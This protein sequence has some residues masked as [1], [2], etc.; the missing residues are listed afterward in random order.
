MDVLEA[1]SSRYS[2]PPFCR[3]QS[4]NKLSATSSSAPR[5]P[6]AGNM[7]P[8]RVYAIAGKRVEDLKAALA[9]RMVTELPK[10]EGTD[11]AIYPEP[12][13]T[14][15]MGLFSPHCAGVPEAS[16]PFNDLFGHGPRL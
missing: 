12:L 6:S 9:P 1:V 16:R 15:G 8:W 10:G 14:T 5:A 4:P 13:S 11:Y 3:P 7:Q 2:C